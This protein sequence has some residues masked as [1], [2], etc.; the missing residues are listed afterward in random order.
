MGSSV[1][2]IMVWVVFATIFVLFFATLPAQAQDRASTA[3]VVG[4]QAVSRIDPTASEPGTGS[5]AP[6]LP[7]PF[8]TEASDAYLV[9]LAYGRTFGTCTELDYATLEVSRRGP[10]LA[11][12]TSYG[13]IIAEVQMAMLAS[14]VLYKEGTVERLKRL[15]FDN[16]YEVGWLPKGR[17]T[18]PR[19]P[20][21]LSTYLESGAGIGYVSET[22]RNSGSRWNWSLLAGFGMERNLQGRTILSMGLQWRHLSNGNMW[23]KGDELHHSNSGTDMI[24]GLATVIYNF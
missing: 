3:A 7:P 14:Y 24:Q 16:G 5:R 17:F 13:P 12:S 6:I 18:L 15:D 11:R 20:L 1:R 8:T 21:G 2:F 10:R 4:N 23:G 9:K 22:Y 19:G